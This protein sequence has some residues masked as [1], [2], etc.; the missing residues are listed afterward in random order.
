VRESSLPQ[1]VEHSTCSSLCHGAN[2]HVSYDR[3]PKQVSDRY[4]R[5]R[6]RVGAFLFVSSSPGFVASLQGRFE[7]ICVARLFVQS[8]EVI[9]EAGHF[10]GVEASVVNRLGLQLQIR[11]FAGQ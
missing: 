5:E 8:I 10:I 6:G 7:V 11:L 4:E 3:S 1:A 9:G 2:W